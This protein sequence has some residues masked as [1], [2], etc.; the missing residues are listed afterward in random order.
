MTIHKRRSHL[1]DMD[2]LTWVLE[3]GKDWIDAETLYNTWA[4]NNFDWKDLE[5]RHA[6]D[7]REERIVASDGRKTRT[8]QIRISAYRLRNLYKEDV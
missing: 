4:D 7:V 3:L 2:A 5:D 8:K 6:I 1:D